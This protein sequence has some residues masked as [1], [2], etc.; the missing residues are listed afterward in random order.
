MN[1]RMASFR[2]G[3]DY[4]KCVERDE[5]KAARRQASYF[6]LVTLAD[7]WPETELKPCLH[8]R[9]NHDRLLVIDLVDAQGEGM[10]FYQTENGSVSCYNTIPP[11][12]LDRVIVMSDESESYC[13]R[14]AARK[15]RQDSRAKRSRT[16]RSLDR[17]ESSL[18]NATSSERR[19]DR[20]LSRN[21]ISDE[22]KVGTV[23]Q[24]LAEN[25][26]GGVFVECSSCGKKRP[27]KVQ[28]SVLADRYCRV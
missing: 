8:R 14:N 2:E 19:S 26:Q 11:E 25:R 22:Y 21:K 10:E 15:R 20:S 1:L 7:K 13:R 3:P 5:N 9:H 24:S 16:D 28:H 27:E 18:Q 4:V 23:E 17:D 6:S 12:F